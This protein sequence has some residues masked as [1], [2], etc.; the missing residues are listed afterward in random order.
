[1]TSFEQFSALITDGVHDEHTGD[2]VAAL[3]GIDKI[4][5]E[6]IRISEQHDDEDLLNAAQ[7]EQI[8]DIINTKHV[9]TLW[10]KIYAMANLRDDTFHLSRS[11]TLLHRIWR[12][13][14]LVDRIIG[15][16]FSKIPLSIYGIIILTFAS[17]VSYDMDSAIRDQWWWSVLTLLWV[18]GTVIYFGLIILSCNVPAFLLMITGFDFW[19]KLY[20]AI[21]GGV[22]KS[23]Y[24]RR[25]DSPENA[26]I[27]VDLLAI[28]YPLLIAAASLIEG[29]GSSWRAS[30]GFSLL[31]AIVFTWR[32]CQYTWSSEDRYPERQLELWWGMSIGLKVRCQIPTVHSIQ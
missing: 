9:E 32:S 13:D 8:T 22:T 14:Q 27:I 3:G 18:A 26:N 6:Y 28:V 7:I 17:I 29:Y 12:N 4:L 21:L 31:F 10:D 23:I 20:Y 24:I 5:T 15:F 16:L 1:M 30:F 2:I 11:D 25:I 19:M